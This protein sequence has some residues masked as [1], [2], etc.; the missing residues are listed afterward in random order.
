MAIN[1]YLLSDYKFNV[2]PKK[3][4]FQFNKSFASNNDTNVISLLKE[5]KMIQIK[6][7][8]LEM[9]FSSVN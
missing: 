6:C 1:Y 3:V 9:S 2:L 4:F 7:M 5:L 8:T